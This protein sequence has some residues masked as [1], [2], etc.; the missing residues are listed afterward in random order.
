[1]PKVVGKTQDEAIKLL[2]DANLKAEVISET[3]KTVEA[4]YVIS[5]ETEENAEVAAGDTVKIHVSTGTG[6][7]QVTMTSVIGKKED[8]AKKEL[9]E[10]GLKVNIVNEENTSKDNGIVLKQ[11]IDTGK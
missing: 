3:S 11:S 2:E 1:V 9:E 6:I 7:K 10:L 8:D 5:Q 4:G